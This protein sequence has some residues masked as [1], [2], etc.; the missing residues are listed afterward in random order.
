MARSC[1]L[2]LAFVSFVWTLF[3]IISFETRRLL[4]NL[5]LYNG[6]IKHEPI[7]FC[8]A[9]CPAFRTEFRQSRE[10]MGLVEGKESSSRG[11]G[12]KSAISWLIG[13]REMKPKVH[14][15]T[16]FSLH[17]CF[18]FRSIPCLRYSKFN[19]IRETERAQS[20][21][22]PKNRFFSHFNSQFLIYFPGAISRCLLSIHSFDFSMTICSLFTNIFVIFQLKTFKK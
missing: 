22:H 5:T 4:D 13:C 18:I 11:N 9:P 15:L 10:A 17:S 1:L 19:K 6:A 7:S 3:K 8:K 20:N 16:L 21:Q 14:L 2:T 12:A